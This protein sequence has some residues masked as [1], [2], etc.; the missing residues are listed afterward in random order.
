MVTNQQ[1]KFYVRIGLLASSTNITAV[2]KENLRRAKKWLDRGD[3][4]SLVVNSLCLALKSL[5][6]ERLQGSL[7]PAVDRLYND[8]IEAYGEPVP[9]HFIQVGLYGGHDRGY[10]LGYIAE[11]VGVVL[12]LS[13]IYITRIIETIGKF[14]TV[15]FYATGIMITVFLV[16]ISDDKK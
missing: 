1:Q 4:L 5:K 16:I 7:S 10:V 14:G 3:D 2:E 6:E 13:L 11:S 15:L 12:I 9:V 8:L